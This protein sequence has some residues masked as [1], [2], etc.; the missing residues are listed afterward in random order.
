MTTE[1]VCDFC[2]ALIPPT[3]FEKG[4]AVTVLKKNFCRSCMTDAIERSRIPDLKP[5]FLT[6]MPGEIA[7]SRGELRRTTS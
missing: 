5:D 7:W 1:A 3:D 2:D 4:E 6:P